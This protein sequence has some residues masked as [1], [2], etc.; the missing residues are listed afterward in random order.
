MDALIGAAGFEKRS[1]TVDEH[2]MFTVSVA[3]ASA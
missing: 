1:T 3:T 2:G